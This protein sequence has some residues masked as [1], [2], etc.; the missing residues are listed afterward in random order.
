[1]H[2]GFGLL[3]PKRYDTFGTAK[4]MQPHEIAAAGLDKA[5]DCPYVGYV[6]WWTRKG[7]AG[8][9]IFANQIGHQITVAP[10]RTGKGTC[11]II[12]NLVIWPHSVVVLD[13]KGENYAITA[14]RRLEMGQKVLVFAPFM[15]G[16]D[17]W[18][19]IESIQVEEGTPNAEALEEE[20]VSYLTKLLMREDTHTRDPYW[21]SAAASVIEA[22]VLFVA[23]TRIVEGVS[24]SSR[25]MEHTMG[26]VYRLL[27]QPHHDFQATLDQMALPGERRI[28]RQ[29]ANV[30][31]RMMASERQFTSVVTTAIDHLKAWNTQR[32]RNITK[33]S[34][35]SFQSLRDGNTSLYLIIPPEM[36]QAYRPIVRA[37]VG[38][39]LRELRLTFETAQHDGEPPV[40]FML[41][42]FPSLGRMEPLQEGLTYLAGY[43]I[44]L[45]L[46]AQ[47][48][49]QLKEHYPNNWQTFI[50]NCA[51]RSFFGVSDFET[52]KLISE[53]AGKAT[54]ENRTLGESVTNTE[55]TGYSSAS[56]WGSST[57]W[58]SSSHSQTKGSTSSFNSSSNKGGS[59]TLSSNKST[60]VG[61]ST[62]VTNVARQLINPDE[63]MR[64]APNEQ[65]V[66]FQGLPPLK[67]LKLPFYENE[68]WKSWADRWQGDVVERIEV[69]TAKQIPQ[70][71]AANFPTTRKNKKVIV[72]K[73]E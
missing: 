23:T 65:I 54:V 70:K 50:A 41:D 40:L 7:P 18:N 12:P 59:T 56:S 46:F 73:Q 72:E 58:G 44:R 10:T 13:I 38:W 64:L 52:A 71:E 37:F 8:A 9:G 26:E 3:R 6:N 4:W 39:A 11:H 42:E 62:S 29:G 45:W 27:T 35:F 25:P 1:M 68:K 57:S 20:N 49:D 34:S 63:V 5:K 43:G 22:F 16:T 36:L 32:I 60:A 66:F 28:V 2:S 48:L 33:K 55:G 30:L 21:N 61:L 24:E 53:M 69:Q 15:D 17:Y 19:P 67:A 47:N 51:V 31:K 14:R